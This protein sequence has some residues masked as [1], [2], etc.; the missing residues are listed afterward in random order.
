MKIITILSLATMCMLSGCTT[1]GAMDV[2]NSYEVVG[3]NYSEPAYTGRYYYPIM[4]TASYSTVNTYPANRG[5]AFYPA[6]QYGA[7][8]PQSRSIYTNNTGYYY[9]MYY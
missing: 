9:R 7:T 8:W 2:Y 5:L 3:R 4:S 1:P 6:G